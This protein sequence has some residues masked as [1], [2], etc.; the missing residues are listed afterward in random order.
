MT[1]VF[2]GI[3]KIRIFIDIF[4]SCLWALMNAQFTNLLANTVTSIIN[5][6]NT[7]INVSIYF[8]IY[9][10]LWELIE[11]FA[12]IYSSITGGI[13]ENNVNKYYF[14]RLYK[15]KPSVLKE[16]NT[17]YISGILHKLV[18]RQ[19]SAYRNLVLNVPICLVYVLYFTV[20]MYKHHWSFGLLLLSMAIIANIFRFSVGTISEKK[21][22]QL[23]H[24][25]G[26]RNKLIIDIVSNINTVQKMRSIK[27]MNKCI[28]KENKQCLDLTKKWT[29]FEELSFCGCKLLIFMYTPL[30]LLIYSK[31]L[32]QSVN[33]DLF[34]PLLSVVSVQL[35][36]NS[37]SFVN[38]LSAYNK[39][40]GSL[41]KLEKILEK[42]NER[43]DLFDG[44]FKS[45]SIKDLTY[46]YKYNKEGTN[47]GK[48]VTVKIPE[49]E[50]NKGDKVCIYG[51]SG[52]GKTTL[53]HLIS[54]EI[55][56]NNT[57]IN[58]NIKDKRLE[59]VFIAQDTEMFDMSLRDNLT[60][61]K[62][63]SDAK[64]IEYLER[65]GMGDWFKSQIDGLDTMLGER[66][67][68]ISTGQRQRLNLIRGLLIDDKEVYL[69]DEPTSNVDEQIEE[70]MIDLI[71]NILGNKTII[72]VTHRP[73]IKNICN[74]I[75]KF[76][77]GII[78]LEK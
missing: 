57:S 13:I 72:V 42:N 7:F 78:K 34:I 67:V 2:K 16:N 37:K 36:H 71:K 66:G 35:V 63:I 11:F 59:C 50:F 40:N 14:N 32:T 52:Q 4:F 45:L 53:L 73:K 9:I 44:E 31:F 30:C 48:T 26:I 5:S 23:T 21:A 54:G 20:Q 43:Q 77:N 62:D 1:K 33:A 38:A 60:L 55:E 41:E 6:E 22:S 3:P 15:I 58:N 24:A 64:L 39:F 49:F 46:S 51:E 19:E 18:V 17:G 25:E 12:D 69:L 75:Y 47:T 10:I 74:K 29:I 8:I 61:G 28:D 65:V 70:N 56:N 76:E 68:F 27:F